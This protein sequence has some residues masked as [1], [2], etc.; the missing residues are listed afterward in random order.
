MWPLKKKEKEAP[1]GKVYDKPV[2]GDRVQ[3]HFGGSV[4][5]RVTKTGLA[6]E[7]TAK[8]QKKFTNMP[9]KAVLAY[10]SG[11]MEGH[12]IETLYNI[13][14]SGPVCAVADF[15][16]F[17]LLATLLIGMLAETKTE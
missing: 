2:G 9:N 12:E 8:G 14:G 15:A 6:V 7:L 10:L 5:T 1:K 17:K 11:M 13:H 4:Q 3:S 16:A